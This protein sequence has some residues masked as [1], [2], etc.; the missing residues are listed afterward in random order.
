[1]SEKPGE[2]KSYSKVHLSCSPHMSQPPMHHFCLLCAVHFFSPSLPVVHSS[3]RENGQASWLRLNRHT[4][5]RAL[6][7]HLSFSL[8]LKHA[9]C[10]L[11]GWSSL[12]LSLF[13]SV[14]L[15]LSLT[16]GTL[17]STVAANIEVCKGISAYLFQS[18]LAIKSG[19]GCKGHVCSPVLQRSPDGH[20]Y[21]LAMLCVIPSSPFHS[22]P[23]PSPP[24][25]L[26]ST[27]GNGWRGGSHAT[28]NL[29]PSAGISGPKKGGPNF[30]S[31]ENERAFVICDS[32]LYEVTRCSRR[33][34]QLSSWG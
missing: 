16:V 14:S 29:F 22:H 10:Q 21:E 1:M 12:S 28:V 7:E 32:W 24:F 9:P 8:W 18:L 5:W 27:H 30:Q 11:S 26:H 20:F 19:D 2:K 25:T 4:Y 34:R 15:C 33:W 17:S 23:A 13:L 6:P 3:G 31:S